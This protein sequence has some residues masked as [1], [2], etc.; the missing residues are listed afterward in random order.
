[1]GMCL[2]VWAL[3]QVPPLLSPSEPMTPILLFEGPS[4]LVLRLANN[5]SFAW[6]FIVR[7][8]SHL[9]LQEHSSL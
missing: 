9:E 7:V 1:M 8:G 2:S 5:A 6:E 4:P 3:S